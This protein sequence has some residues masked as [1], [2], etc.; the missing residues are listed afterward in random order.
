[1][2]QV[3]NAE[4]EDLSGDDPMCNENRR[5]PAIGTPEHTAL[6]EAIKLNFPEIYMNADGSGNG[7]QAGQPAVRSLRLDFEAIG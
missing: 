1:M 4:P 7:A 2:S 3:T 5:F 6:V